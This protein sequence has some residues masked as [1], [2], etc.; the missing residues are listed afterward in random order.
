MITQGLPLGDS[1]IDIAGY[2]M[3]ACD[4][5]DHSTLAFGEI[6]ESALEQLLGEL[7]HLMIYRMTPVSG[8]P[9]A[10]HSVKPSGGLFSLEHCK[11]C[12]LPVRMHR[13]GDRNGAPGIAS[14]ARHRFDG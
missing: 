8:S 12:L 10:G 13:I 5:G 11:P 14:G 3:S 1:L 9:R 6:V 4:L 2:V 7:G